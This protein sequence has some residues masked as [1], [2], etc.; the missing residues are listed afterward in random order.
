MIS[1]GSVQIIL[2]ITQLT[3]VYVVAFVTFP[4]RLTEVKQLSEHLYLNLLHKSLIYLQRH[5]CY[6]M[7]TFSRD[8]TQNPQTLPMSSENLG[9]LCD[10]L[11]TF[12]INY[13]DAIV[14]VVIGN[15]GNVEFP[16]LMLSKEMLSST[17]NQWD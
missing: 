10:E 17:S 8:R 16:M 11:S 2:T 13:A 1:H 7:E 5:L 15:P 6:T 3:A 9:R 4:M 14:G 12:A